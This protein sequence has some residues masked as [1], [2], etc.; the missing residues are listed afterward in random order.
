MYAS[1]V[2]IVDGLKQV[3]SSILKMS[4]SL[5]KAVVLLEQINASLKKLTEIAKDT[6]IKPL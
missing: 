1:N 2:E 3:N 5:D 6:S 4:E